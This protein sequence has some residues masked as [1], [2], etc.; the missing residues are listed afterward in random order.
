MSRKNGE[1][2]RFDRQ[3]KQ[4]LRMKV[5]NTRA[6]QNL[7]GQVPKNEGFR[8]EGLRHLRIYGIK[9]IVLTPNFSQ[10]YDLHRIYKHPF[11]LY[12]TTQ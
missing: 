1:K 6:P 4:K 9:L 2:A 10:K 5:R 12:K 7:H 8:E 11:P 3:R